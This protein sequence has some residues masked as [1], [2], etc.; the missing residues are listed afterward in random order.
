MDFDLDIVIPLMIV[1]VF[2]F[3]FLFPIMRAIIRATKRRQRKEKHVLKKEK[4][5]EEDLFGFD[6]KPP[7]PMAED[8]FEFGD[9]GSNEQRDYGEK[10]SATSKQKYC[11]QCGAPYEEGEKFCSSCG[12]KLQ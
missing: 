7:R 8:I 6:E 9:N 3:A 2:L 11:S 12:S 10:I 1:A 4:N 5:K